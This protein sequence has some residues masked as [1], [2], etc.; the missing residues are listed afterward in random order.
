M[1]RKFSFKKIAF[2]LFLTSFVSVAQ[3]H[4]AE[5]SSNHVLSTEEIKKEIKAD[6]NHHIQDSHS[7]TFFSDKENHKHY[8][9]PLPVIL[10]DNG[11]QVF[12]SSKFHH[13]ET[14]AE[15]NGNY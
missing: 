6:I 14:V 8:G 4:E 12:S 13:G 5:E 15:S 1:P 3:H 7:F 10:W 2:L 11:L 9:F